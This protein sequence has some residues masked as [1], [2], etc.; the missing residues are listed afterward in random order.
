M[1][2]ASLERRN[3]IRNRQRGRTGDARITRAS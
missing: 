2:P 1:F 3:D